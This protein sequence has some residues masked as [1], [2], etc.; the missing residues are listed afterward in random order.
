MDITIR[1]ANS[2]DFAAVFG[3]F[4]EFSHFQKTPGKVLTTLDELIEDENY[5]QCLVAED[6]DKAIIGFATFFFAYYSWT[7][8]AIYLDDLYVTNAF[9]N[10]GIGKMLLEKVIDFAKDNKCKNVR[11]RVSKWNTNAIDF[12]KKMGVV[13]DEIDFNCEYS[14]RPG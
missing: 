9:R 10:Q 13:I 7:G 11:W 4:K 1:K 14:V 8:R 6:A 3:L 2:Q 5:F 12:Y